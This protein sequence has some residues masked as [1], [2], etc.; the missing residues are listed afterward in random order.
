VTTTQTTKGAIGVQAGAKDKNVAAH[1]QRFHH[2]DFEVFSS[3]KW[4]Q[5][6]L[7]H[8]KDVVVHWPDGHVTHGI[9][10]HIKDLAAMAAWTPDMS[11]QS[12]PV[13]VGA[14]EWTSVIGE[15]K[16]SFSKPMEVGPGKTIAPTGK[17][18]TLGMCTVGRWNKEGTMDEEYLFWDSGHFMKQIG[19]SQ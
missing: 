5:L 16:G 18:Y 19:L 17:S 14:E 13:C 15:M 1:F 8:A 10:Q 12:H 11:I 6:H 3:K 2:L 4:D 7:S 9:E